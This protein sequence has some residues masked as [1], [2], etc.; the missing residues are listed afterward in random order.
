MNMIVITLYC[1]ETLFVGIIEQNFELTM[2]AIGFIYF[3]LNLYILSMVLVHVI[4][5]SGSNGR[6]T[7]ALVHQALVHT[8][9]SD[10]MTKVQ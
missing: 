6:F 7:G 3:T 1:V 9:D 8:D 5:S 4:V 10:L 2:L